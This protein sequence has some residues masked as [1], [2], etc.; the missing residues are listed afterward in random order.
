MNPLKG[1]FVIGM[2]EVG[3]RLRAAL[4]AAGVQPRPVTRHSG[5]AAALDSEDPAPRIVAVREEQLAPVIERFPAPL[6]AR[7]VLVQNGFLEEVIGPDSRVTRGLIWFTSKGEFFRELIPS[8]FFGRQAEGV[9]RALARGGL[10]ARVLRDR[11]AFVAELILKGAFNVV[12]GLPLA[13]HGVDLARY[14]RDHREEMARLV[15]E[16]CRAASAE[17]GVT[18]SGDQALERLEETTRELGWVRGGLKALDL[19]SGAIARF[20]RRHGVATPVTDRLLA[21]AR[22]ADNNAR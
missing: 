4:D 16:T 21:A 15:E 17:Y 8:L 10:G 2:G 6:L 1:T 11:E 3:H 13:V 7:L 19:R 12:V 14:R 9:A 20:G 18:V 5:W 22:A